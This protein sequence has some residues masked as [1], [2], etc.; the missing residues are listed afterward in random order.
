MRCNVYT[1][2][3]KREDFITN[4]TYGWIF[5][6]LVFAVK[7]LFMARITVP[8]QTT[9]IVLIIGFTLINGFIE[10]LVSCLGF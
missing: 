4:E 6:F 5:I 1:A 10:H 9:L 8:S 2:L 7:A 3:F